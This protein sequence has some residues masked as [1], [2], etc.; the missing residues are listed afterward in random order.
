MP[1]YGGHFMSLH[2]PLVYIKIRID[3]LYVVFG[4]DFSCM[5]TFS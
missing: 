2:L 1:A 4:F 3:L 5:F